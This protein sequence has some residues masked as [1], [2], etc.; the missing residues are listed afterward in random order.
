[1]Y[2]STRI[3]ARAWFWLCVT[4]FAVGRLAGQPVAYYTGT[5]GLAGAELKAGLQALIAGHTS[6]SYT[7]GIWNAHKDL[8]EDPADPTRLILF[9][10]QASREKSAQDTGSSPSDAWNREHLWPTSLGTGSGPAYTDLFH[11]V[12]AYK[13][14]NS[15]RG[16][17][18][19]ATASTAA[20]GYANPAHLLAP[21]CKANTYS[22]EP[23]DGQKGWTARAM[24]YMA[25]RYTHLNLVD[26]PLT[27]TLATGSNTMARLGDLLRWNRRFPPD[28]TETAFNQR[29]F[30]DYQGNRNPYI[31]FPEFADAVWLGYPS[32]GGWRLAHFSLAQL[33][34][35]DVA[36]DLADPDGDGL[37]NLMEMA[38]LADPWTTHAEPLLTCAVADGALTLTFTRVA[39]ADLHLALAIEGSTD[40]VNWEP[41]GLTGAQVEPRDN[42]RETVIVTLPDNPGAPVFFRL[43]VSRPQ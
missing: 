21:A 24:F 3:H 37:T 42:L 29:V 19:F 5:Q 34:D 1:M 9:Y 35:P 10:S 28:A 20:S 32:W 6:L 38:L 43:S 11:L 27:Q 26:I 25:T 2:T 14:V 41:V 33:L 23:G 7:P 30:A 17:K 8:Y 40:L 36:G 4:L 13:G 16:N 18:Y 31:D 39:S 22:W 12:P 15:A